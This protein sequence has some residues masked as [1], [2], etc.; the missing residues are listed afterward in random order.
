MHEAFASPIFGI[1]LTLLAYLLGSYV[2]KKTGVVVLNAVI[3]G[4]LTVVAVLLVFGIS[5][6]EFSAGGDLFTMLLTPATACMAV[7]IYDKRELLKKHWLPIL[8]GCVTGVVSSVGSVW[9]MCRLFGLSPV[10]THSLLPKSVTTAIAMALSE[11]RGGIPSITVAAVTVTGQ[12]GFMIAPFLVRLFRVK[13]PVA[14]GLGIGACSH[15]MGTSKALELG[16]T[17]GAMASLSMGLCGLI[18]SLMVLFL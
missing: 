4:A 6:E 11:A 2:H 16:E 8:V 1:A 12:L 14:A 13:N 18:T 3:V 10:L 7:N 17:E 9:L 15:A 5:F